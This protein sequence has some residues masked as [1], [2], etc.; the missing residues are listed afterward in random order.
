MCSKIHRGIVIWGRGGEL[1]APFLADFRHALVVEKARLFRRIL[2]LELQKKTFFRHF[3]LIALWFC[4]LVLPLRAEKKRKKKGR[5]FFCAFFWRILGAFLW[6]LFLEPF[7]AP[8][9]RILGWVLAPFVADFR[10]VLADF[11]YI[12]K[13][14]LHAL[15]PP[16]WRLFGDF[17][18][19]YG[20]FCGGF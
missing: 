7:L 16:F 4:L 20:A 19:S 13:V 6:H 9:W 2:R 5:A 10:P 11:S 8:F 12:L 18:L 3:P 14:I 17:R 15:F 1:S